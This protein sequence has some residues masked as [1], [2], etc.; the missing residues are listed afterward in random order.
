MSTP[1]LISVGLFTWSR[2]RSDEADCLG[3]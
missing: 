2:Q 3:K 1:V